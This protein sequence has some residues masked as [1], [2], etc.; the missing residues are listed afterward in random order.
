MLTLLTCSECS[1]GLELRRRLHEALQQLGVKPI[2]SV[3]D[4]GSLSRTDPRAAYPAPT[5]LWRDRDLFGVPQP[6]APYPA[7]T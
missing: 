4:A 1:A 7:P 6:P 5:V 3:V 2:F